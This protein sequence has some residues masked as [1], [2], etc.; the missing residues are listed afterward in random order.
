MNVR[1]HFSQEFKDAIITKIVNR[2]SKTVVQV[3][4]E[5]GISLSTA[6]GWRS[7]DTVPAMK[8]K[9]KAKKWS[10]KEKLQAVSE[11]LS[12]AEGELGIYLRKE[13]LH[14]Q[15]GTAALRASK[16]L[17]RGVELAQSVATADRAAPRGKER[18]RSGDLRSGAN[19]LVEAARSGLQDRHL[20]LSCLQRSYESRGLRSRNGTC[21]GMAAG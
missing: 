2:G 6:Y 7:R 1:R 19:D 4:E 5:E 11:T 18:L 12:M 21:L 8:N 13:G 20:A 10:A 9:A 15:P 3:F 14:S 16:S 17:L